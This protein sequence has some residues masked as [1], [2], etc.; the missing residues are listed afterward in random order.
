LHLWIKPRARLPLL[1]YE[2][3]KTG[4]DKFDGLSNLFVGD[5]AERIQEY[6]GRLPAPPCRSGY[7]RNLFSQWVRPLLGTLEQLAFLF[8]REFSKQ[9]REWIQALPSQTSGAMET[10]ELEGTWPQQT[11]CQ[12]GD[13]LQPA[14]CV[15]LPLQGCYRLV[16]KDVVIPPVCGSEMVG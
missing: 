13:N 4:R 10:E 3:A 12:G 6:S 1:L 2:F 14:D 8:R 11:F 16:T 7:L 9:D 15:L 5:V